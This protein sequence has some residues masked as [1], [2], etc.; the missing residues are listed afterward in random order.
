M[1]LAILTYGTEGDAR[2]LA[3]LGDALHAAGHVVALLGDAQTLGT[4][5]ALGLPA[6]PLAGDIRE[7]FVE[8]GR[9]GPRGTA[10]ALVELTNAHTADWMRQALAAAEG[11]DAIVTSGLAS[12]VGLS[13]AER[14]RVPAIGAG[15]FPLT[16][17][18]EFPSPFLPP[19]L[20]P[21]WLNP[22]SLA[23]TNHL[24]WWSFKKTLNRARAEVLGLPAWTRLPVGHPMLYGISPTL[25]PPPAD[26]PADAT[27]CGQWVPPLHDT[28][29]PPAALA[30]FIAAG[31]APVYV[32]F[33]SMTGIDMPK[34]LAA[35]VTALDGR[36][37]VFWPGWSGMGDTR[38]PANVLRIDAIPHAWL[39]PRMAAVIHHGGSGTTH[40]ALR[41]G[42]PSI[43]MPFAGDQ[44][45]WAARLQRLGVA[46]AALS[47]T[48]P[49]AKAIAAALDFTG[50]PGVVARA[51]E[52]GRNMARED[53][54]ATA[55]ATI[56]KLLG[57]HAAAAGK[58]M[59]D[60]VR[61]ATTA[62]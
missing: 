41:A 60:D 27:L 15:M 7:L 16:P 51:A 50:N 52:L 11:C 34:M 35:L 43:V 36:R 54:L 26:W 13:V 62:S 31:P 20:V 25:L 10:K 18:R 28:F 61:T 1:K 3:A 55:V 14:L 5:R 12:F 56:E 39:F 32:G 58:G 6:M 44:P 23:L 53:G 21:A 38:L 57:K 48:H 22:T 45:F 40:S 30:Q 17:S 47:T 46:P 49:E 2:P 4:A 29:T 33:G 19:A 37:A 59:S 24:L 8:W 42:K 9:K